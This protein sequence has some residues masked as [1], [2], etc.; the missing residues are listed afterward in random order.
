[1]I[2]WGEEK[3]SQDYGH[4]CRLIT[5]GPGS[6]K[7]VWMISDARRRT[8]IQY[9]EE[10]YHCRVIK[11][12]VVCTEETRQL[13]GWIFT[14]GKCVPFVAFNTGNWTTEWASLICKSISPVIVM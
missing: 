10:N 13:R 6:E 12:R 9:F 14:P 8:D 1:M 4:F 7:P 5:S 2:R 11:L 3:R